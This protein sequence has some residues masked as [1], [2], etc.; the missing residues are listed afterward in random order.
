MLNRL[1]DDVWDVVDERLVIYTLLRNALQIFADSLNSY[2]LHGS[3]V[4]FLLKFCLRVERGS[5]RE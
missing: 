2:E 1:T 3:S 5:S 4:Y